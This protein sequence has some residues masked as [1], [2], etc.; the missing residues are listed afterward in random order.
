MRLLLL[1]ALAL[2]GCRNKDT[3]TQDTGPIG[4]TG[5]AVVDL[6]SDGSPADEDCDDGNGAVYPGNVETPYN[7]L[8]D[9]CDDATPDDDLDSDGHGHADDCDDEDPD[10]H[11]GATEVC[12]DVDDD[13]NELID[14]AVGDLFHADLDED[15]YGDP[16]DSVQSCDGA[17]GYVAD[18]TDCDDSD[19]AVNPGATEICNGLDDDCDLLIDDDD[20]SVDG[21]STW[22]HDGDGDGWGDPASA[23]TACEAPESY[24]A[25]DGDCDDTDPAVN[26]GAT[27]VC[28][29]IDDDCDGLVDDDDDSVEGLITTWLDA[30]GDGHGGTA[31]SVEACDVAEGFSLTSDDCDDGDAATF[32]GANEACD[33][34][35]N[36]CDGMVDEAADDAT[37]WYLDA[38]GDGHGDAGTA[39]DSCEGGSSY[40]SDATDC[41][42]TDA[43]VNPGA[44][45]VCNGTDD[46]CDSLTDDDDPD[47]ADQ[48]TWYSDTDE[49]GYG[50]AG[51]P[52]HACD[53]PA[54][55]VS[56]DTDCDD[57]DGSAYPGAPEVCDGDDEDCD[58]LADDDDPDLTDASTWYLDV[59][60]DGYGNPSFPADACEAPSSYVANAEDCND[61]QAT[62]F[63]GGTETCDGLDNDCDAATDEGLT[64]TWYADA[65]SDGHGD[66]NTSVE[67]CAEPSGYT[68]DNTDCDDTDPAVSPVATEVCN[69]VDDDC[70][71]D[72]DG[73]AVDASTWHTDADGDGYGDPA[74]ATE[75]CEADSTQVADA[76]DCDDTDASV[77]PGTVW[78]LDHDGDGYGDPSLTQAACE[79]PSG[80]VSD[81]TDCDDLSAAVSPSAT[82]LCNGIDDDCDGT[83]D[84]DSSADA[85]TWYA[86]T[87]G[88]GH[89]DPT[90]TATA[91]EA[92]SGHVDVDTDCDDGDAA[93]NPDAPEV[94][95][96]IDDDCDGTADNGALGTDA[97]CA[98][99]SCVEILNDDGSATSGTYYL[100]NGS[101]VYEAECDMDSDGGGWT[102]IGSV[103]NDGSRSWDSESAFVDPTTWGDLGTWESADF[104]SE[105][106]YGVVG[107]GFLVR[108]DEYAVGWTGI[109]SGSTFADWLY[110]EYDSGTCSTSFLGGTP[111]YTEDL[112][113]GEAALFDVIV[114]AWDNNAD[115][116]PNGNE[117][118]YLSF[119][120]SSCCWTN[121]LGNTP[122]GYSTWEVYDNSMLQASKLVSESC[123]AGNYPCNPAGVYHNSS[124]ACYDESCK[125]VTSAVWVR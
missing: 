71:G 39:I 111:D 54:N 32:P 59:D 30:D 65:D 76:T 114:R 52:V 81:A 70:D 12:N 83:T 7:G 66:P 38:D 61:A 110:D 100:D 50:D 69:G 79:A 19:P 73:G 104:K 14:D 119:T 67:D 88:D 56:D 4:S 35:N 17:T 123:T 58:A 108:T 87:D 41:D 36:D 24:V 16:A 23:V 60:G 8:D 25:D 68:A 80:Y 51:A 48:G 21:A 22:L 3:D 113:S 27:E 28:N 93:V 62:A 96:A 118:A 115:C 42:D 84:P 95:N 90:A 5:T 6:D 121:G 43:A 57:S 34:A 91:C 99:N 125:V 55:T 75:A 11:P 64:T 2:T 53:Q 29:G 9:D 124:Y 117:N 112:S 10:R 82:E 106:W 26:P 101:G 33:E 92:P 89:G 116:F 94:C 15:G 74:T 1:A 37:A 46:D 102:L 85:A 103:V 31:W 63:P 77:H 72:T 18:A 97:T 107:D 122:N 98:A 86:D 105:A 20:P 47:I 78:Y 44:T 49:D 120:L 13:C 109:L 40:V 45:E